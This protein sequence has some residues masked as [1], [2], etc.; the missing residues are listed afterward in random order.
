MKRI[1]HIFAGLSALLLLPFYGWSST[2]R[3]IRDT[4]IMGNVKYAINTA[5][6]GQLDSRHYNYLRG[7]VGFDD[8]FS[9]NFRGYVATWRVN[10]NKLYL[11]TLRGSSDKADFRDALQD[12]KDSRGNIFASW[13]SG[14][15]ICGKGPLLFASENG[16][17]DLNETEVELTIKSGI[18][19]A[20]RKYRNKQH[21]G[22]LNRDRMFQELPK[23]F[24][25]REF[26]ELKGF[27]ITTKLYPSKYDKTG[28][29]VDWTVECMRW[30]EEVES[31]VQERLT[32]T[33]RTILLQYD[34]TTCCADGRWFWLRRNH[35]DW[36]Y[37][38]L[39]FKKEYFA[40][41]E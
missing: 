11:E 38:P 24:N 37:W 10:G 2:T 41:T 31:G 39:I 32:A 25:Y 27:R 17:D 33:L 23:K 35:S 28:R 30:P 5:P 7:E 29:I 16:W 20:S 21:K 6:L 18:V 12:F 34:C 36:I 26:P 40:P 14:T 13:F 4:L 9:W 22:T 1:L 8:V 3:Q 15:V 19:T